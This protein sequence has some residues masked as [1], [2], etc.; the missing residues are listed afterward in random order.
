MTT[1]PGV[2]QEL[3]SHLI[4]TISTLWIFP[5]THDTADVS[6]SDWSTQ[7]ARESCGFPCI[8]LAPSDSF[9][10]MWPM[11]RS[12]IR[13]SLCAGDP[14]AAVSLRPLDHFRRCQ[15]PLFWKASALDDGFATISLQTFLLTVSCQAWTSALHIHPTTVYPKEIEHL[16]NESRRVVSPRLPQPTFWCAQPWGGSS[17]ACHMA[18]I[19]LTVLLRNVVTA[20]GDGQ[21]SIFG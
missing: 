20:R 12:A 15:A 17:T 10:N 4:S 6:I 1:A 13:K 7:S 14:L 9:F 5:G 16:G 2:G 11:I 19:T 21:E 8:S 18:F 3:P